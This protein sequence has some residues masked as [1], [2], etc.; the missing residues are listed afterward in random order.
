MSVHAKE[1]QSQGTSAHVE[2]KVDKQEM[3][4]ANALYCWQ[5]IMHVHVGTALQQ[6]HVLN[7]CEVPKLPDHSV[8]VGCKTNGQPL[9]IA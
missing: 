7:L 1:G 2:R 8:E 4:N 5:P 6:S 9:F 3:R